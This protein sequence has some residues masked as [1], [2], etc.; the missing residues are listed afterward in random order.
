LEESLKKRWK[1]LQFNN[2]KSKK[3]SVA[4]KIIFVFLILIFIILIITM[5]Y[6]LYENIPGSPEQLQVVV[7]KPP[8]LENKTFRNLEQFYPNM[9]FN[10]NRI[11]YSIEPKCPNEKKI[12]AKQGFQRLQ[13]DIGVI[14][15]FETSKDPDI[16]VSC[17]QED[18]TL[19]GSD[20]FIAGEGGARKIVQTGRYNIITNGV[21][22]LYKSPHRSIKCNWPNVELHELIHVF[23]F[24][25]SEN[26]KSVMYPYLEDCSQKL[27]S[28][29][30]IELKRLYSEE[31]FPD[32]YF[33]EV[34]AVK[35]GRYLDFNLTIKNSGS[36]DAKD[37]IFSVLDDQEVIQTKEIDDLR[38][39]AGI[40]IQVQ[41]LKLL[42]RNP[43]EISFV[44]DRAN[45]IKEIDEQNNV[46]RVGFG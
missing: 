13:E 20:Y 40:S 24:G 45:N 35:K 43:K 42:S 27:D 31:N 38:F 25:H 32:L 18:K 26:P 29:I 6:L 11:S 17:S 34:V 22:L 7:K 3:A 15:F 10:H 4:G 44:I 9:K 39:G 36:L 1:M 23:G 19:A 28:E 41:N 33:E 8:V 21:I 37:I 2:F 30:I 12:R 14:S 46:A 16:E 5:L